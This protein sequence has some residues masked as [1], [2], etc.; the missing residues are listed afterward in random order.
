[1][2]SDGRKKTKSNSAVHLAR[3]ASSGC[4][5][6]PALIAHSAVGVCCRSAQPPS[7]QMPN[8]PIAIFPPPWVERPIREGSRSPAENGNEGN[9]KCN[10]IISRRSDRASELIIYSNR[11]SP[12]EFALLRRETRVHDES[13]GVRLRGSCYDTVRI[14]IV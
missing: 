2:T 14:P 10:R 13:W 8:R 1:M 9:P 12:I 7:P 4:I 3:S 6:D 11:V 5:S